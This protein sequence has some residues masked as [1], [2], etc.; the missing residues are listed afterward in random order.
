MNTSILLGIR[1]LQCILLKV[2]LLFGVQIV[3]A[4]EFRNLVQPSGNAPSFEFIAYHFYPTCVL[5]QFSDH[6]VFQERVENQ[7]YYLN[8]HDSIN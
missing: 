3:P 5:P 4:V 8:Q 6:L 1:T 2:A 7:L